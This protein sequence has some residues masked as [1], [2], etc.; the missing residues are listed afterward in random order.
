L[1]R[2]TGAVVH[3]QYALTPLAPAHLFAGELAT[4]TRLL[5]EER[6]IGEAT[7]SPPIG[8]TEMTLAAWRG[9]EPAASEL[10]EATSRGATARGGGRRVNAATS[11]SSVLAHGLGR[12]SARRAR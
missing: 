7:G 4:A 11:A 10:I 9:R 12:H 2:E 5:E 6:L 1:A 3:L 8:Y